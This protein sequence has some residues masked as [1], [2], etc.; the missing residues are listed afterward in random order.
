MIKLMFYWGPG[1]YVTRLIRRLTGGPYSHVEMQFSDGCRF[2]SSGH[3]EYTGVHMMND[4]RSYTKHWAQVLIQ[5]SYEQER[6][7]EKYIFQLVGHRFD[8]RGLISF[9]MPFSDRNRRGM[10]CSSVVLDVLQSS[11]HMFPGVQLKISP[12]G[13][14][15]LFLS[16]H[17]TILASA[18]WEGIGPESRG[19]DLGHDPSSS[20]PGTRLG[21]LPTTLANSGNTGRLPERRQR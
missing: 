9:L 12:N 14:Y 18:P 1:D 3:G 20:K 8:W 7:A 2:F 10:Y 15:R 5:S 13:L 21:D 11:L 4:R 17:P 16:E 6:D 19:T